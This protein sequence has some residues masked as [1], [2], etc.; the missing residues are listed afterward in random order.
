MNDN[1]A[2]IVFRG[3]NL[4]NILI[5][6]PRKTTRM[7]FRATEELSTDLNKLADSFN[8]SVSALISASLEAM[9]EQYLSNKKSALKTF[10]KETDK[11]VSG[12]YDDFRNVLND[13]KDTTSKLQGLLNKNNENGNNIEIEE[14]KSE[15]GDEIIRIE[16]KIEA[17]EEKINV[18]KD[19]ETEMKNNE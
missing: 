18:V 7:A 5:A 6:K 12:I 10:E 2:N 17:V 19:N 14:Y 15:I 4:S 16:D 9:L 11:F 13:L 3:E 8:I 1:T